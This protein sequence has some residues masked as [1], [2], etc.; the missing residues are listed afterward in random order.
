MSM[1]R[2]CALYLALFSLLSLVVH[3]DRM[4]EFLAILA[5]AIFAS[6]YRFEYPRHNS[7]RSRMR[8]PPF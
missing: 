2:A 3:L 5:V 1:S 7:R 4:C 8:E 6:D